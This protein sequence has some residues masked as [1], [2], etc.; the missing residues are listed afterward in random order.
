M[1]EAAPLVDVPYGDDSSA[2]VDV[3]LPEHAAGVLGLIVNLHGGGWYTGDKSLAT[4]CCAELAARGFVVVNANY[5]IPARN[6]IPAM[7]ADALAVLRWVAS[8][9][10]PEAVREASRLG[11]ALAGDSA[12]AHIAALTTCVQLDEALARGL[13]VDATAPAIDALVCWSG[14]LSLEALLVDAGDPLAERFAVYLRAL[15]GG[16]R[17]VERLAELDPLRWMSDRMPPTLV[18]TSALDFFRTSSLEYVRAARERGLPLELLDYDAS[19]SACTHSW[20]LDPLLRESQETYDLTAKVL[21]TTF[22]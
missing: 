6:A 21:S 20:Q 8:Q 11:I 14:A 15:T 22:G 13:D 4:G 10:A 2:M 17:V 9:D 18:A 3:H 5:R 12:G 1:A 19:H 16:E 7:V